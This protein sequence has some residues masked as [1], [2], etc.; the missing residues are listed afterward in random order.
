LSRAAPGNECVKGLRRARGPFFI[1][2][3]RSAT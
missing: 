2:P 3:A 1:E